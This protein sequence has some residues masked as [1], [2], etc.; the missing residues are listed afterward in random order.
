MSEKRY[1]GFKLTSII[2]LATL[3]FSGLSPIA[4][5]TNSASAASAS[6]VVDP[7]TY[8]G[9]G[10]TITDTVSSINGTMSN[11]THE[12]ST[13]CGVFTYNG[14]SS[15]I[16]FPQKNFGSAFSISTWIRASEGSTSG[17]T[18]FNIQTLMSNVGANVAPSGFKVFIN[19]WNSNDGKLIHQAGNNS[20]GTDVYTNSSNLVS[21]NQWHHIVFTFNQSSPAVAIYKD[22]TKLDTTGTPVSSIGMN[23]SNWWLGSMGGNSYWYKGKMGVTK[24]Y[25]TVLNQTE[26]TEDYNSTSA[27]YASTP[28]CPTS[29]NRSVTY[30]LNS[31]SGTAPTQTDTAQGSTFTVASASGITRSG[32]TFAGWSNGSTTYQ[33]GDT[34]TAGASNITLTAQWTANDPTT[35]T[36]TATGASQ[37]WT[38]PSGITSVSF[39][40]TGGSG[41]DTYGGKGA[42]VTGTMAVTPGETLQ[43]NVG[44]R[45]ATY[46]GGSTSNWTS[47]AF[48]GGG[49]GNYYGSGGG[50]ASD[51]RKGSYA[52]ADRVAVAGGGGGGAQAGGYYAG[53]GGTPSGGNGQPATGDGLFGVGGRGGTQSAGGAG[54]AG[55]SQ[56]GN[57]AGSNG[58]LGVGG[59]GAP[60][61]SGSAGG[62][63]GYYLSLIHI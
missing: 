20:A 11:V 30:A 7:A 17:Q 33:P 60:A 13:N 10:T 3:I 44:A 56:C 28:T 58:T 48:G 12:A 50:G 47:A 53:N 61:S 5:F 18:Q 1:K 37:T 51:I 8:S 15:A 63:G 16:Q 55:A 21:I 49:R 29:N 59:D 57:T 19:N 45:G 4:I 27:R 14:S 34:Y 46:P 36:F 43:I 22:G 62:G 54:G 35:A 39:S 41:G 42:I 23:N 31:G 25:P 32:Y 38:V 26:V 9:S 40:M 2:L 6:V 52:L 24:I